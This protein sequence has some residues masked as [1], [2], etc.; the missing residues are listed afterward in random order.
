MRPLPCST[1]DE[2]HCGVAAECNGMAQKETL[3][4]RSLRFQPDGKANVSVSESGILRPSMPNAS[5]ESAPA[6][7]QMGGKSQ[8]TKR[9]Y[10]AGTPA[11]D[12]SGRDRQHSGP[13]SNG[14]AC[15]P[16][17]YLSG[18]DLKLRRPPN[19]HQGYKPKSTSPEQRG[20]LHERRYGAHRSH[21][22]LSIHHAQTKPNIT[23]H[24]SRACACKPRWATAKIE[25]HHPWLSRCQFFGAI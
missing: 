6:E 18:M 11:Y 10:A 22:I 13:I 12:H 9:L 25:R 5:L 21:V 19:K 14:R 17:E 7:L 16:S 4:L 24:F 20:T 8:R 15:R 3:P 1:L 2:G 23:H